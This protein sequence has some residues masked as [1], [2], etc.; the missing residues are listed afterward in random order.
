[1]RVFVSW[2]GEVSQKIAELLRE[3]IPNVLQQAELFVS[4]QDIAK[5]TRGLD[6]IGHNLEETDFG[7]VVL[8][9][10]NVSAPWINFEAGALSKSLSRSHVIPLLCGIREINLPSSPLRQFQ[11]A[12]V[13]SDEMLRVLLAINA[14]SEKPLPDEK[15]TK[16]FEMWWPEFEKIY[17]VINLESSKSSKSEKA[18]ND[19]LADVL[20]TILSD[21]SSV[22]GELRQ[23]RSAI[24]ALT[25]AYRPA[26]WE[27]GAGVLSK[28]YP[29]ALRGD[30][31]LSETDMDKSVRGR[32]LLHFVQA[33]DDDPKE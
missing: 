25:K 2:S 22:R 18:T 20:N 23:Q 9:E 31:G 28:K 1:M 6:A 32:G 30:F 27:I 7:I 21:L 10:G 5:G 26:N 3:W 11:H 19:Q 16:A 14:S 24:G 12:Q 4:S 17:S 13:T 33:G 8:T 29:N 15:A